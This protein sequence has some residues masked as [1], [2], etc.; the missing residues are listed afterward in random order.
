MMEKGTG[1]RCELLPLCLQDMKSLGSG[2]YRTLAQNLASSP[3]TFV[4]G[5]WAHLSGPWLT[6]CKL[7]TSSHL[8]VVMGSNE[9][10]RIKYVAQ[11]LTDACSMT[12]NNNN[13]NNSHTEQ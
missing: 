1:N 8:G 9:I 4:M 10:I 13:N 12:A 6:V 11:R 7:G 2:P 5:K 3:I